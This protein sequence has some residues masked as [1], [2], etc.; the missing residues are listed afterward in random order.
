[1]PP[2]D[3]IA[4]NGSDPPGSFDDGLCVIWIVH[5]KDTRVTSHVMIHSVNGEIKMPPLMTFDDSRHSGALLQ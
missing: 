3:A 2:G 4:L 5:T 1:M